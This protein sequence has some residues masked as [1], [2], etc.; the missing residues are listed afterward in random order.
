MEV[1]HRYIIILNLKGIQYGVKIKNSGMVGIL[2]N[3][4][5][6]TLSFSCNG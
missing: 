1:I 2:L 5:E 6:G 4:T 3:M